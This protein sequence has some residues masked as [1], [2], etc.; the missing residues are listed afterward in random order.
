MIDSKDTDGN[1]MFGSKNYGI[2]SKMK[3]S[4]PIH[5]HFLGNS[6]LEITETGILGITLQ[7]AFSG[8]DSYGNQLTVLDITSE[9]R[10]DFSFSVI[11][12]IYSGK[13]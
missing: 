9:Y 12:I 1:P 10:E 7:N 3:S 4:K 11:S 6:R 5:L 13:L 2:F 8:D